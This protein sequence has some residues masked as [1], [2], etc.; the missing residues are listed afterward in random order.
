MGGRLWP[1]ICIYVRPHRVGHD[2]S[3]LAAAAAGEG[4]T[5]KLSRWSATKS[6]QGFHKTMI[7]GLI[8]E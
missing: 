4:V 8:G 1:H 7:L 2:R 5:V 3:N 6:T